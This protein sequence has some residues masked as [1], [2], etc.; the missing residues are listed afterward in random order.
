ML[1]DFSMNTLQKQGRHQA[2]EPDDGLTIPD[3]GER[4]MFYEEL[5]RSLISTQVTL[6]IA[7]FV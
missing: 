6:P 2:G 7:H 1:L 3:V 4:P 5:G